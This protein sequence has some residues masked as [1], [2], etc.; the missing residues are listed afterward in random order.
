MTFPTKTDVNFALRF[1]T[2]DF[3]TYNK[4]SSCN[5]ENILERYAWF[6]PF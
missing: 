6:S 2:F 3:P 4:E 1:E 5:F